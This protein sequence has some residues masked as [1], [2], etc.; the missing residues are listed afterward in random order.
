MSVHPEPVFGDE[1]ALLSV[2]PL[3]AP[4]L[5][6]NQPTPRPLLL[7][8]GL[9]QFGMADF[10]PVLEALAQQRRVLVVDLP[11]FGQS[12]RGN[13]AYRPAA[14]ADFLAHVI[15]THAAGLSD[16][17]GHS[18]GGAVSLALAGRY[19]AKVRRLT[20]LDAAGV[21]FR[22][23]LIY[24]MQ[25]T[26]ADE[27]ERDLLKLVG[28]DLWRTA[29]AVTS[30]FAVD[31]D[32]VLDNGLL[33]RSVLSGDP[34]R[35]AALALLEHNFDTELRS[36]EAPTL[37]IWGQQDTTAPVRTFH[38]LEERLPIWGSALLD[39]VGH[40]PIAGVPHVVSALMAKF[41]DKPELGV[42]E[43]ERTGATTVQQGACVKEAARTFEGRWARLEIN[44]C[45]Q[46]L[47]RDAVIDSLAIYNSNVE[48][49]H[50]TV[51]HGTYVQQGYV[52]ATGSLLMGETA[53]H[54]HAANVDL[55]GVEIVGT[56]RSVVVIGES[57]MITS[58][59]GVTGTMGRQ[60]LHG[61]VKLTQGTVW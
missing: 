48:L 50:V 42:P 24:E 47:I 17:A 61:R 29:L 60:S 49:R 30:P 55:A 52:R 44:G 33:R 51:E 56:E 59:S 45:R 38:V 10:Y 16:V 41:L 5:T 40:N 32:A 19:P 9:S 11:G 27:P 35:I 54:L 15:D 34:M 23:T 12:T 43:H 28:R 13:H 20:L 6:P 2:G 36:V 14:Y 18:M 1:Y 39:G 25:N 58:V 53:F 46:V 4:W 22:E 37:L 3:Q 7:V 8:H 31:P 21:L 57:S 26:F